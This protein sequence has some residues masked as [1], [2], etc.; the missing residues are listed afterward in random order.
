MEVVGVSDR[1]GV[2]VTNIAL[3]RGSLRI[4]S[5]TRAFAR[6]FTFFSWW[7]FHFIHFMGG[8]LKTT[9]EWTKDWVVIFSILSM[10][11]LSFMLSSYMISTISKPFSSVYIIHGDLQPC[12]VLLS[13]HPY[14]GARH[15]AAVFDETIFFWAPSW[16]QFENLSCCSQL[17]TPQVGNFPGEMDPEALPPALVQ[18]SCVSAS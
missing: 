2:V 5:P 9:G 13:I 10:Q 15:N 3:R 16:Q 8:F 12:H 11:I 6:L 17:T 1:G 14:Q 18:Q 4:A 7:Y